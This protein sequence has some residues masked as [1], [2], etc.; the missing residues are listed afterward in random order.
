L[1]SVKSY[2][3]YFSMV[4][5]EIRP[6]LPTLATQDNPFTYEHFARQPEYVRVN[7][8]LV[9]ILFSFLPRNFFHVDVATGTGLVPN[10]LI[11]EAQKN[12]SRGKIIGV[13]PN[14]DSI[15][16][17]KRTTLKTND[18][19]VHYIEGV[20]QNLKRLLFDKIPQE[21]VD[22]VSIHDALHE[23]R[24]EEDK[25]T[26]VQ[27]MANILKPGG[28]FS[29]N[30]AFTTEAIRV[31]VRGWAGWKFT[32]M[33]I[34]NGERDRQVD[35]MAIHTPDKYKQ[36]LKEAGLNIIHEA[37]NQVMLSKEALRAISKYPAFVKGVFEDMKGQEHITVESKSEALIQAL[38]DREIVGLPRIWYELVAQKPLTPAF[39]TRG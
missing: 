27:S 33:K 36:M 25:L 28:V 37:Q 3:I 23:I 2:A 22:G 26:T 30:S 21:G 35:T 20:G 15:A 34:L 10:L 5:K 13:D 16:I 14:S 38:D 11:E 19:Q 32:A 6:N 29:F 18:V 9:Q 8:E 4:S 7:R 39:S 31:N 1:T 17:A 12:G 24:D